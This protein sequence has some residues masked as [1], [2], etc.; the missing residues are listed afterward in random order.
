VD[1][2]QYPLM[3]QSGH[4]LIITGSPAALVHRNLII[5]LAAH[6]QL[7]A[8]YSLPYFARSGGLIAYGPDA[9]SPYRRAAGYVDR[10]LKG[11]AARSRYSITSSA[12]ESGDGGT[13]RPSAL[14]VVKLMTSSCPAS[15]QQV[16]FS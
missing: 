12:R 6:H 5:T 11:T 2:P 1:L 7:P 15:Y 4:G 3:T 14:A 16:R 8:V 13:S 9:V 10:I